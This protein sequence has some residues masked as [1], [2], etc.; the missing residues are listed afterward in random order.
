MMPLNEWD[1]GLGRTIV[2]EARPTTIDF[3]VGL[4]RHLAPAQ[5]GLQATVKQFPQTVDAIRRMV[6][7]EK[8]TE[9]YGNAAA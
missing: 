8:A 3:A 7:A 2:H 6:Q 4:I 9:R 1:A 5:A